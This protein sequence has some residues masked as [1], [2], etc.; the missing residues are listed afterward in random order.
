MLSP[1][2][3]M[4]SPFSLAPLIRPDVLGTEQI[5]AT[6]LHADRIVLGTERGTLLVFDLSRASTSTAP[7]TATLVNRHDGFAK[8]SIEQLGVIKELNAL[9]CLSGGDLTLH[10]FPDFA[11]LSS[12]ASQ[13]KASASVFALSTEVHHPAANADVPRAVPEIHTTLAVACKRRLILLSWVDGTWNP[14]VEVSLPHQ[15]RGMA[16]D[17]RR[18]VAG[19]ST[20]EYGVITLSP[21]EGKGAGQPPTLGDLFSL[22]LPLA[23][24]PS[25]MGVPGLG[26]L[27][28][29]GNVVSLGALNAL[30]KKLEKNG[31]VRVPRRTRRQRPERPEERKVESEWLWAEEWGWQN[32]KADEP[33][34]VLV[35]RDNVGLPLS[36]TGKPRP[37]DRPSAS[38]PS[39]SYHSS[40]N[41]ALVCPPYVVSLVAPTSP[42]PGTTASSATPHYSLAVHALETLEPVQTLSLPPT[43]SSPP[44]SI[45]ESTLSA[46]NRSAAPAKPATLARLLTVSASTPKPPLLVLTSTPANTTAPTAPGAASE[47]TLWVATVDSW[48]S[49]LEELGKQGRWEEGI[50]LLRG[51]FDVLTDP[52]PPPL[53]RRLATLHALHLFKT[54]RYNLAID[55]FIALDISPA[56]VVCL[57]PVAISGKLYREASAHE[58][59]FGGRPHARVQ[60]AH[61]EAEE[62][63]RAEEEE[64]RSS[65]QQANQARGSPA[66]GSPA[67]PR[68]G[69]LASA[70]DDD[71]AASVKSVGS[72]L[73]GKKSWLR[74]R[75]PSTTLDEIAENAVREREQ[76]EKLAAQNYSRSV[77]ELVRYLTDRRQKYA[78]AFAALLPSSRPT[79]SSPRPAADADELLSLPNE[80][81]TKLSPDQLARV[82]QVVDTALFRSYLATKP[83]M[84]GPLC[85]IE[86][87][88]EVA[89]VEELLLDAKKYRELLDLYNGKNMHGKAVEMLKRMS[90]DEDDPKEKVEPT[91]RYLQKLGPTHLAVI[92]DASRWVFEQ[93]VASGLQIFCA[94]FEEVESLPRHAVMAH[95]EG[96]GRDV[97]IKYLE[98]IIRQLDEQG[99]DFH[100]K[101]IE[102]YLQASY[103]KLLDLLE[104]SKSY[105]ADR[106][107]GR[108]PS[109]DMH[110]VRAV[111]LGR[112]GRHEGALQIYVYQL[113][114]HATAQ[115]YCKR[116]YDSDESMRPTIFHLL[117]RLYLRPRQN[118]PLFFG[119]AL[120]LLSTQAARIDPIEAFELLPPLVAVSDIKV[121]LEKTLRRSNERAREAKMVKAIGRSWVDQADREIVDLEERR[122]KVTEG[123]V[124]PVCHK[125]IGNSVIAIHNPQR[126]PSKLKAS[127]PPHRPSPKTTHE[128]TSSRPCHFALLPPELLI[129]IFD[130]AGADPEFLTLSKSFLHP[131]RAAL[132]NDVN[133]FSWAMLRRF[134]KA[135]EQA[136][137]TAPMVKKLGFSNSREKPE[138][139]SDWEGLAA[140]F[141]SLSFEADCP[142]TKKELGAATLRDVI[143]RLPSLERLLL[144][145]KANFF[146]VFDP[147][148]LADVGYLPTLLG[149]TFSLTAKETYDD[150]RDDG[151]CQR[152]SLLPNLQRVELYHNGEFLPLSDDNIAPSVRLEPASWGLTDLCLREMVYIGPEIRHLFAAMTPSLRLFLLQAINCYPGLADDLKLLPRSLFCLDIRFGSACFVNDA[153]PLPVLDEALTGFPELVHL[154]LSNTIFTPDL[155]TRLSKTSPKIKCLDFGYFAPLSGEAL[156]SILRPGK[157]QLQHLE[158]IAIHVCQCPTDEA[159]ARGD[160]RHKPRWWDGF[161]KGDA[162][163]FVRAAEQRSIEVGGN[164]L[165]ALRRCRANDGHACSRG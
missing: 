152:L 36:S 70:A 151:I 73:T 11:L 144:F 39:I 150:E 165:C 97:C 1:A 88:C 54:H 61:A 126:V 114:D 62:K 58:E 15:I 26:G 112:L 9:V 104:T 86:N 2:Q 129:R 53:S 115:Q 110:E 68:K 37:A 22:P 158:Y 44:A 23:E 33:G 29:L 155:L 131:A 91:V 87:W 71:D 121:Y 103:R 135:L 81:L 46:M 156:L 79:P 132:Y 47:Q 107:L 64:Q 116:V 80:P 38:A 137:D 82:A 6:L 45:A 120:A 96:V 123:R 133:L 41:E 67:R 55:A 5:T 19:F 20:G 111:L 145:G 10:S 127:R 138:L 119:P 139:I 154:H 106:I 59:V 99:A 78:Q 56:R 128:D 157:S 4:H 75:E 12:F 124:C 162:E 161:G 17:G 25:R 43:A 21:L 130:E 98:H 89:E 95:L 3:T 140:K 105:R 69:I 8:K 141:A 143:G 57:Y 93:D 134:L 125:R 74:D 52:L 90:E 101:L 109:E 72:R 50:A 160:H 28:G 76:Q 117:L 149:V 163:R 34:E 18:L 60:A 113:E 85:R 148:F 118:H 164:V 65:A 32:E 30:S 84:V 14:Q 142:L 13:T 159:L 102:L 122:V 35:V 153:G 100:E 108:L 136:P 7:P 48:Q 63:Q 31:V 77:D 83:V 146:T 51:S 40:V 42:A 27:G 147:G 24:R 66:T 49:Q 92:L 16:F 94:D